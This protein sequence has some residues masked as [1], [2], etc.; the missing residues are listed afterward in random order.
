MS[1]NDVEDC[2]AVAEDRAWETTRTQWA[3]LLRFGRGYGFDEGGQLCGTVTIFAYED[4][5]FVGMLLVRK[6]AEGLGWGR[7]L[8][9]FGLA[10]T[11]GLPAALFATELGRPL[12]EKIGFTERE[13]IAIHAGMWSGPRKTQVPVYASND[14]T[15]AQIDGITRADALATGTPRPQLI[16]MLLATPARVALD[17]GADALSYAIARERDGKTTIG[18]VVAADGDTALALIASLAE[19]TNA[20]LRV[21]LFA[22]KVRLRERLRECGL[23][24]VKELPLLTRGAVPLPGPTWYGIATKATG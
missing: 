9:E 12:Y 19:K 24:C 11:G 5:A 6:R 22:D 20:P 16:A 10:G 8:V 4:F 18:P 17:A 3:S 15:I 13:L 1:I 21:Q 14:L 7:R 2:L 23:A